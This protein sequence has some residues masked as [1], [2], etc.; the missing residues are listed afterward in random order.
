MTTT[1]L[2]T[3]G[4]NCPLPILKAKKALD[5]LK[6]LTM[7]SNFGMVPPK[8][9]NLS[10]ISTEALARSYSTPDNVYR[11]NKSSAARLGPGGPGLAAPHMFV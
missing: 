4:M 10:N 8:S 3:K 1:T 6:P 2:D 5:D 9:S 11:N 7:S